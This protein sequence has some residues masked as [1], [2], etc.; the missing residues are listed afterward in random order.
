VAGPVFYKVMSFALKT[1]KIPPDHG[2]R[3]NVR[4]TAP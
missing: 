3:P 1:M 4:L 2:K